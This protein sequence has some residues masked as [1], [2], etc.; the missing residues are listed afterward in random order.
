MLDVLIEGATVIDG[1]GGDAT[2]VPV[3]IEDGRLTVGGSL[4]GSSARRHIDGTGLVLSPGFVDVHTHFDAQVFWDPCPH[5]VVAAWR[6]DRG[7]RELRVL[8]SSTGRH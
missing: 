7:R 6:H 8:H 4:S 2:V 1:T 5:P 3:G